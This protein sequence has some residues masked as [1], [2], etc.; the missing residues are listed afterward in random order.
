MLFRIHTLT[1]AVAAVICATTTTISA[2]TAATPPTADQVSKLITKA[3]TTRTCDDCTAAM[4]VSRE[5]ARENATAAV[6]LSKSLCPSVTKY[7][8]DVVRSQSQSNSAYGL[9]SY[10]T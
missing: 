1:F 7:P 8:A 5:F 6:E 10:H 9:S 4:K 3:A 2:Q